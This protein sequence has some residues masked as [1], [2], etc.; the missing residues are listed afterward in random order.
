MTSSL[1]ANT[2]RLPV[3]FPLRRDAP[4]EEPRLEPK[5][6]PRRIPPRGRGDLDAEKLDERELAPEDPDSEDMYEKV[7]VASEAAVER[8]V[9]LASEG[10]S[11][12]FRRIP[13]RTRCRG[14]SGPFLD[15]V[16]SE[17]FSGVV[18]LV[19]SPY[20]EREDKVESEV[21]RY[22]N[23]VVA[24]EAVEWELS[25]CMGWED[26]VDSGVRC[27]VDC[28]GSRDDS[29]DEL[30]T[31][32]VETVDM[33]VSSPCFARRSFMRRFFSC[34]RCTSSKQLQPARGKIELEP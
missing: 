18:V 28:D 24:S 5:D 22:E 13:S 11:L 31:A 34:N 2:T 19:S 1:P 14:S 9:R 17:H 21:E 12:G 29:F 6:E 4:D 33:L 7:V 30:D 26:K 10:R 16:C 3:L 27:E 25:S 32:H 23:V 20:S 8:E 15:N